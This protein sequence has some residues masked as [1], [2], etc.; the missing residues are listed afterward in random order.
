MALFVGL[1]HFVVGPEYS[2]P[3]RYFVRG[4]LIDIL[5]PLSMYLLL[6]LPEHPRELPRALRA[7]LVLAVG[8]AVELLQLRGVPIFGRTFDPLDLAAYALG[9]LLAVVLEVT[10]LSRLERGGESAAAA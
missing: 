4:Y 7:A 5:L 1:L 3:F 9:V 10:V 2:G 6:S 8:G